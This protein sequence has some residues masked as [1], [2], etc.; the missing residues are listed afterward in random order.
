MGL[1]SDPLL[2]PRALT[3]PEVQAE[4]IHMHAISNTTPRRFIFR[5]FLVTSS[6][7]FLVSFFGGFLEAFGTHFGP[8]NR[9]KIHEKIGVFFSL[10][11]LIFQRF[12][13][14][15]ID[16]HEVSMIFY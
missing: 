11:F 5:A 7:S 6:L 2:L 10:I 1:S 8:Q 14:D 3:E 12:L 9:P 16:F 4:Q 13:C 15:F